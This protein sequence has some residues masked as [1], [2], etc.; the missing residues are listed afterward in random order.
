MVELDLYH[1]FML[2]LFVAGYS[3]IVLE[4]LVMCDKAAVALLMAIATWAVYFASTPE[5][6]SVDLQV[7]YHNLSDVSQIAFFLLGALAIVEVINSHKG[8]QLIMRLLHVST[9]W[10]LL[11]IVTLL[12]FFL[13][14]ILDNLTT[15][16]VMLSLLR[17]LLPSS[18]EEQRYARW[19]IGG[20]IVIAANAGGAWT[21]IGDVTTTM[22]W[23]GGQ[24]STL[25][26]MSSLFLPSLISSVVSLALLARLLPNKKLTLN[27]SSEKII[28]TEP[29]C[30]TILFLGIALLL[31]VPVFKILTG[32]PPFMGIFFGLGVL[33]IVTDLLHARHEGREYLR[34]VHVFT[35]IDITSTF[36][37]IG[38]LLCVGALHAGGLLH[39]FAAIL[40]KTIG[41]DTAIA[42][43]LGIA[44]AVIDNVPL[45][46]SIMGM[47]SLEQYPPDS[48]LW[49]MIAFCAGTGGSILIIGSAA[50]VIFMAIEKVS[51]NWYLKHISSAALVGYL[52][53]VVTRAL[54]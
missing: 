2:L 46:A 48:Y 50:G 42:S 26:I 54:W 36:F 45:V 31:F 43:L 22:L 19:I 11:S 35:R 53:G 49:H 8:F 37:F 20:S 24:I 12:T 33:W 28:Q 25:S 40:N 10:Q 4:Q 7:L 52:A 38:I 51:F 44:S 30:G 6:I 18:D 23:I 1:L 9:M 34:M 39:L 16:I 5:D 3:L 27:T 13:S 14:S 21:P 47:Y 41:N 32:L 17:Q 15:T 29:Y